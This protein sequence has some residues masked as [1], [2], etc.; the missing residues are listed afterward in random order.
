MQSYECGL[1]CGQEIGTLHTP[2][3]AL[4][5]DAVAPL[6]E[7]V[8]RALQRGDGA[9]LYR[10][11]SGTRGGR[12][13]RSALRALDVRRNLYG[14][15]ETKHVQHHDEKQAHRRD[16]VRGRVHLDGALRRD[17]VHR[18]SYVE[19]LRFRC[20]GR[21]SLGRGP[22]LRIHIAVGGQHCVQGRRCR[23][24]RDGPDPRL[25][26][27]R[28]GDHRV[29]KQLR[30]PYVF[31]GA[32]NRIHRGH[33]RAPAAARHGA[34]HV[35]DRDRASPGAGDCAVHVEC[36]G[37]F[38]RDILRWRGRAGRVRSEYLLRRNVD[39][40]GHALSQCAGEAKGNRIAGV[41]RYRK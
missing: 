1:T 17:A 2:V 32:P 29:G 28:R 31:W 36:P 8:P 30:Q 22:H 23:G 24:G 10:S 25:D 9:N 35:C 27:S 26:Q 33:H 39:R 3:P 16:C 34:R 14:N 41:T 12:A 20:R 38:R 18:R 40:I 6:F 37:R 11:A 5:R 19:P 13:G 7:A 4:V 15:C 21:P